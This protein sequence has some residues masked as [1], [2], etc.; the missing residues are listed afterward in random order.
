MSAEPQATGQQ[1]VRTTRS[2][3]AL[4]RASAQNFAGLAVPIMVALVTIPLIVRELG[5][6]RFGI[7]ALA[8]TVAGYFAL[9]D[10]GLGRAVTKL[11]AEA[12]AGGDLRRLE[13]LVTTAVLLQLTFGCLAA[14]AI[15]LAAE[16]L[17]R[18]LHVSPA[19]LDEARTGFQLL[20]C[21]IPAILLANTYRGA[22]EAAHRFDLVNLLRAPLSSA[23][24]IA[25]LAGALAGFGA[26]GIVALIAL[27]R[28][29]AALA[30]AFA[31]HRALHVPL[32]FQGARSWR[33]LMHFGGWVSATSVL[34][35]LTG[36][37]DRFLVGAFG[38]LS[39]VAF[40]AAPYELTS[41]LL[42]VPGSVSAVLLPTLSRANQRLDSAYEHQVEAAFAWNSTALF[43]LAAVL[44]AFAQPLLS[45]WLGHEYAVS[46]TVPLRLLLVAVYLNGLALLP[47]TMLESAGRP[48][49][50]TKYHVVEL[51]LYLALLIPLIQQ[52][53]IEGAALAWL[54]RNAVGLMV[55]IVLAARVQSRAP[56]QLI[57]RATGLL[58]GGGGVLLAASVI[59]LQ[60][61]IGAWPVLLVDAVAL[62]AGMFAL[63]ATGFSA[64]ARA[65]AA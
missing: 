29:A 28:V 3:S 37:I 57:G 9:F 36:Y 63:R 51:P 64:A 25:T 10:L 46:A 6:E 60:L 49:L 32:R 5:P 30:Y 45:I 16:P 54:A 65:P 40:Y 58:V 47:F 13:G 55:L 53:G 50:V 4:A 44:I 26:R 31:Y 24:Y 41:K 35:P 34:V 59:A 12:L 33:E 1:A 20:A 62:A 7:I 52:R 39:A 22:L 2:V 14:I 8:W 19:L 48:D 15:A 56:G 23:L 17:A 27:T 42:I 43:A 61:G 18:A 38:S 11:G 21:A